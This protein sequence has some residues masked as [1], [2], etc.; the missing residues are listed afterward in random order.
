MAPGT[1]NPGVSAS[2]ARPTRPIVSRICETA[3]LVSHR[4]TRS[5]VEDWTSTISASARPSFST[6]S[7]MPVATS[8]AKPSSVAFVAVRVRI[9]PLLTRPGISIS[10][11]TIAPASCGSRPRKPAVASNSARTAEMYFSSFGRVSAAPIDPPGFM[12]SVSHAIA[13]SAPAD[14]ALG[15]TYA[16]VRTLEAT[17][18]S[19]ALRA[20]FTRPPGVSIESTTA[21]APASSAPRIALATNAAS[22]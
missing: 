1:P 7:S 13:S 8:S 22:P 16:I 20:A 4:A 6:R 12:T 19:R 10:A 2:T 5:A 15:F 17:M 14:H 9:L 3:S 21:D 11:S 18:A